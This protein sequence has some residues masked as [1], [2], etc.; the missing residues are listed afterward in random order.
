MCIADMFSLFLSSL[1]KGY[2]AGPDSFDS[3]E[4]GWEMIY[5]IRSQALRSYGVHRP[6]CPIQDLVQLIPPKGVVSLMLPADLQ[7]SWI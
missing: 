3:A 6:D 7:R 4:S 1:S 2:G 5:Q